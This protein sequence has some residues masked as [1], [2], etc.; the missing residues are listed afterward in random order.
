MTDHKSL[1]GAIAHR[2]A[3]RSLSVA[4]S[5]GQHY[6]TTCTTTACNSS[7]GPYRARSV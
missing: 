5:R 4:I 7:N 6:R 3:E 1:A 2:L